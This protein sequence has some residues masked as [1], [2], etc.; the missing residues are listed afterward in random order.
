MMP[1][2]EN[3][4]G[5][6]LS[7]SEI[8]DWIE[9]RLSGADEARVSQGAA[10]RGLEGRVRQMQA[11]RHA[12]ASVADEKA[13]AELMDK[14]MAALERDALLGLASGTPLSDQPPV[15]K[16]EPAPRAGRSAARR[17]LDINP[18]RFALAAGLVLAVGAA[19][20]LGIVTMLAPG[21]PASP[22][23]RIDEL[24]IKGVE[25]GP[26]PVA[27]NENAAA[28]G[29][30]HADESTAPAESQPAALAQAPAPIDTAHAVELARE[31]RLVMRVIASNTRGLKRVET[32]ASRGGMAH[33]WRLVTDVP[34][35]VAAA[36][37]PKDDSRGRLA[38]ASGQAVYGTDPL[39]L[40]GPG[41]ALAWTSPPTFDRASRVRGTYLVDMPA[42]TDM[43]KIVRTI[44][45]GATSA[46]VAFE[47]LPEKI[48][49]PRRIEP[50]DVLWWTQ[51][52]SR[53][54]ARVTV[55]VVVEER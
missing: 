40:V 46:T 54:T 14:V 16:L 5:W 7:E 42:S 22:G 43:L 12:L 51:P 19:A 47:E 31:G 30:P 53:W 9:G 29:A 38:M 17:V 48:E 21:K 35:G 18:A 20:Y 36:V 49:A 11:N 2:S 27:S 28:R 6:S 50:E 3:N 34:A 15:L 25:E 13:P 23:P 26:V 52:A 24:A 44:F 45:A 10:R 41:A 33:E 8:L 32:M 1:E 4:Q 55:P 39:R 37:A